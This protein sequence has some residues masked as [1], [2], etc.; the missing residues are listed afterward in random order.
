MT[1]NSKKYFLSSVKKNQITNNSKKALEQEIHFCD[2]VEKYSASYL[3]AQFR[4]G[5]ALY[6]LNKFEEAIVCYDRV[7]KLDKSDLSAYNN[8]GCALYSIAKSKK[9]WEYKEAINY[10]L[11]AMDCYHLATKINPDYSYAKLNRVIA[12]KAI[13]KYQVHNNIKIE[14]IELLQI[15]FSANEEIKDSFDSRGAMGENFLYSN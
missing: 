3:D 13:K 2:K 9:M 11:Q 6:C 7:I 1:K 4:K 8:K 15:A 12:V 10:C 14:E 5:C